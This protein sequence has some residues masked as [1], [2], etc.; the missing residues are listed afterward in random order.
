MRAGRSLVLTSMVDLVFILLI[1]FLLALSLQKPSVTSIPLHGL[2]IKQERQ[3]KIKV[4][5]IH[6]E[7]L[8][9]MGERLHNHDLLNWLTRHD[10]SDIV[11]LR[12]RDGVTWQ[13]MRDV[14]DIL[15]SGEVEY[16]FIR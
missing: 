1:F 3:N 8:M 11:L 5:D 13:S 7:F 4:L 6:D 2:A 15:E 10:N 16:G 14:I 12:A 9:F